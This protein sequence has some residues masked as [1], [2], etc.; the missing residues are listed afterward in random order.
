MV[1]VRPK[2]YIVSARYFIN[3]KTNVDDVEFKRSEYRDSVSG[4]L[5]LAKLWNT[6]NIKLSLSRTIS[7][8]EGKNGFIPKQGP[9]DEDITFEQLEKFVSEGENLPK[10][11]FYVPMTIEEAKLAEAAVE[12]VTGKPA[13]YV[14]A[15]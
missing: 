13:E 7:F 6:S 14:V 11:Q 4:A 5:E 2:D 9:I 12:Y 8:S 15:N 1:L 3:A 10:K